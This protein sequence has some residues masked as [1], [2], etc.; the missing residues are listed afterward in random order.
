MDSAFTD[1]TKG[2]YQTYERLSTIAR[3]IRIITS[4][5]VPLGSIYALTLPSD[6]NKPDSDPEIQVVVSPWNDLVYDPV[7][8]FLEEQYTAQV[9][10]WRMIDDTRQALGLPSVNPYDLEQSK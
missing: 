8:I 10:F 7:Q 4:S 9:I 2:A 1:I 3:G 6:P 5:Y